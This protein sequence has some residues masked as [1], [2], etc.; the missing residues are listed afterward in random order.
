MSLAGLFSRRYLFSR[1][2]HSVINIIASVSTLSVAIPVAAMIILLSVFNGFET[3][4]R[5]LSSTFDADLTISPKVGMS[6]DVESLDVERIRGVEGVDAVSFV[7]EQSVIAAYGGRRSTIQLKG[8]DDAYF[9]VVPMREALTAGRALTRVGDLN[10]AY[11]GQGVAYAL[12]INTLTNADVEFYALSRNRFSSLLPMDNYRKTRLPASGIFALDAATDG[13]YVITS[14]GEAQ[15]LFSYGNRS[16][17]LEL[18]LDD[19]RALERVRRDVE[20]LAGE[21]FQVKSREEKN[22]TMYGILRAEKWGIFFISLMVL[23]VASFSIVGALAMLIIEKRDDV[24]TLAAMGAG[25]TLIRRIFIG[26][27]RLISGIGASIGIVIGVGLCLIQQHFGVITIP[28]E[29]LL[30]SQYPVE[31]RLVDLVVVILSMLAV[32]QLI[33]R[34]T[35]RV[36]IRNI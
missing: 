4:V 21:E 30:I 16:T 9:D 18:A 20:E 1:K 19:S 28:S 34:L 32:T 3:L 8:V 23:I 10:Y 22:A 31:L 17:A 25:K 14:L 27:G 36:M 12:G 2:S 26:E 13:G 29:S 11:V 15:R 35:V 6:F 7:A 24:R 5:S 33:S